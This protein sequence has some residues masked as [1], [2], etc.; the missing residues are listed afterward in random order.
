[1][2]AI[3]G[4]AEGENYWR[5]NVCGSLFSRSRFLTSPKIKYVKAHAY[6]VKP[7]KPKGNLSI[8]GESFPFEEFQVEVHQGLGRFLSM[9]GQ[10][11]VDFASQNPAID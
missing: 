10:Y 7:L 9:Y 5:S 1:L 6:R 11:A 3:S 8:D 4:A 2:A